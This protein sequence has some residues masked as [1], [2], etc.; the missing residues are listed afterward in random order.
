MDATKLTAGETVEE[1]WRDYELLTQTLERER[2]DA[3][4]AMDSSG[5]DTRL[6]KHQRAMLLHF[7]AVAA[8][9]PL[10]S[11]LAGLLLRWVDAPEPP[12]P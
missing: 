11:L 9:E 2:L 4:D 8:A 6:V 1:V 12:R 7:G 5:G 10:K 3:A